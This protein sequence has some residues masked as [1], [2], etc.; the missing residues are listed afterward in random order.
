MYFLF[1]LVLTEFL[2]SNEHLYEHYFKLSQAYFLGGLLGFFRFCFVLSFGEYSSV[3]SFYL[4]LCLFYELGGTAI[5]PKLEGIVLSDIG[6]L[7]WAEGS[8]A[9]SS[10]NNL[11]STGALYA[12]NIR[13]GQLM[14]K[15]V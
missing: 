4:T 9:L 10:W 2:Q 3:S 7:M 6:W 14:L 12:E 11:G 13:E 5:S 8:Q 15:W 1:V